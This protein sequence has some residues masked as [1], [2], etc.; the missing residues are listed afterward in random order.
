MPR[1]KEIKSGFHIKY[2]PSG[3]L[4]DLE[5]LAKDFPFIKDKNVALT[6]YVETISNLIERS[7]FYKDEKKFIGI[8]QDILRK[9]LG[10]EA[11]AVS[12]ILKDLVEHNFLKIDKSDFKIKVSAWKYKVVSKEVEMIAFSKNNFN[13]KSNEMMSVP[14]GIIISNPSK[15]MNLYATSFC[16]IKF[17][18]SIIEFINTQYSNLSNLSNLYTHLNDNSFVPEHNSLV[19]VENLNYKLVGKMPKELIGVFKILNGNLKI[20]RKHKDSRVY[21][22]ITNLKK[23][24]KPFLRL[25]DKPLIGFDIA[26][27]QPLIATIAFQMYSQKEYGYIKPD[28]F[29]YQ[30]SCEEGKFYE[31]FMELNAVNPDERGKFK[32]R[33]FAKV[34]YSKN[35]EEENELK[36]QFKEKYPTCYEAIFT[37]KGDQFYSEEYKRFPALMTEI[38]T[39][40]MWNTNLEV[41][42]QGYDMVNIFDS[43]YSDDET[44]IA[45]AKHL[46]IEKFTKFGITPTLKDIDYRIETK[47]VEIPVNADPQQK[48][49]YETMKQLTMEKQPLKSKQTEE[50]K[51]PI[52]RYLTQEAKDKGL[53]ELEYFINYWGNKHDLK[54]AYE[55]YEDQ[56][57][58]YPE[59][60]LQPKNLLKA[61]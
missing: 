14:N 53:N 56:F 60:K 51:K 3:S 57:L 16:K 40:I 61:V 32:G 13:K 28:I 4:K 55:M 8:S 59:L 46:V 25:N 38:E 15:E 23:D 37:I 47:P 11:K 20:S 12:K 43:L 50:L 58:K 24:F 9:K 22:N 48:I 52:E 49:N 44:A 39:Y 54:T 41:I 7:I 6:K 17:D 5:N 34:F 33:F 29:E 35:L 42:N 10:I 36:T 31:Y 45:L 18:K 2:I 21:S 19:P 1:K 26:N 27:S 30:K